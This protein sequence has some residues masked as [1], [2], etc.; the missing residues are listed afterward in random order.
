MQVRVPLPQEWAGLLG[1]DLKRI[2][3][4]PGAIFCHKGRFVSVW[5]TKEDVFKALESVLERM[6]HDNSIR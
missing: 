3:G 2:S 1:D 5:E 6:G 4:I